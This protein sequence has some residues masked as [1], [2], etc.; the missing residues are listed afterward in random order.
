MKQTDGAGNGAGAGRDAD[1][2]RQGDAVKRPHDVLVALHR[3]AVLAGDRMACIAL[4]FEA[5]PW[6]LPAYLFRFDGGQV[7]LRRAE[8]IRCGGDLEDIEFHIAVKMADDVQWKRWIQEAIDAADKAG[9]FE[10]LELVAL[11]LDRRPADKRLEVQLHPEHGMD[12]ERIVKVEPGCFNH[13]VPFDFR[14]LDHPA[15]AQYENGLHTLN[16]EHW[17][18]QVRRAREVVAERERIAAARRERE[19][20]RDNLRGEVAAEVRGEVAAELQEILRAESSAAVRG[21]LER[22]VCRLHGS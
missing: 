11:E 2:S 18:Q 20:I 17:K 21:S 3:T 22:I 5:K 7:R 19:R 10:Q 14:R 4:A 15:R 12:A 9:D 13:W 16:G 8:A 1:A 6:P